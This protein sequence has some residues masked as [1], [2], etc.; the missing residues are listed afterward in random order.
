MTISRNSLWTK[1]RGMYT[2]TPKTASSVRSLKMQPELIELLT[3]YKSW[4]DNYIATVGDKWE[5][6]DRL[7]TTWDG[8]PMHVT[9]PADYFKE[10]CKKNGLRYCS[11]HSWRHLNATLMI[12]SGIDV[13]TVQ[14]CLGH[15]APTTTMSCYLHTFQSAQAAAMD[16]VGFAIRNFTKPRQPATNGQ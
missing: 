9:S 6:T 14:A 8:K 10:F 15:S 11:P 4:Q 12:E 2:D 1:E 5:D 13:K 3:R 16:A 7:F